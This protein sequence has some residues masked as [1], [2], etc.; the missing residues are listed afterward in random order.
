MNDSR[1]QFEKD[2]QK[3]G[4]KDGQ[5]FKKELI[6]STKDLPKFLEEITEKILNLK[7]LVDYFFNFKEYV[8]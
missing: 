4:L 5:N 6:S 7:N 3:M 8:L 1:K 2:L